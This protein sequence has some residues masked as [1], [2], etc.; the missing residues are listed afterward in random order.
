MRWSELPP[1]KMRAL[2]PCL[3]GCHLKTD[4]YVPRGVRGIQ[5][6]SYRARSMDSANKSRNVGGWIMLQPDRQAYPDKHEKHK[7]IL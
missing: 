1:Q 5:R 2:S 4:S 3:S 6:S 7:R